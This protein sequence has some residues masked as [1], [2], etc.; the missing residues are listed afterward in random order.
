MKNLANNNISWKSKQCTNILFNPEDYM[1]IAIIPFSL[2]WK[3][4]FEGP[5]RVV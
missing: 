3:P 2:S 5:E 4:V 1:E